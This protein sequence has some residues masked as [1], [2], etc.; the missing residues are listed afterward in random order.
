MVIES[1]QTSLL[2][3][4]FKQAFKHASAERGQT[5]TLWVHAHGR[6]GAVGYGEGCPREYVTGETL[7]G[8]QHFT[9]LHQHDWLENIH[10]IPSLTQWVEVH[11]SDIDA[12]PA[13]WT[14]VELSLLD[15]FGRE[16]NC[17]VEMLLGMKPLAGTFHYTAVLGDAPADQFEKQLAGYLKAGF[18][19]FKVKLSG[20]ANDHAKVAALKAAGVAAQRVRA[21]AN[22]L[23]PDADSAIAHLQALDFPFFALEEPVHAGDIAGMRRLSDALG[24]KIILDES[25]LRSGQLSAFTEQPQQWIVNLRVSKM[26]G[27]LRSLQLARAAREHGLEIIVGAHVGETSILTRAALTVAHGSGKALLAQEGAFGTHLLA[28]DMCTPPLM[29]GGG[30]ALDI[31]KLGIASRPGWGLSMSLDTQHSNSANQR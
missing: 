17:S 30:G 20:Q 4:P 11:Q 25:L 23:W 24:A 31:D 19:S 1:F 8:A 29:F 9:Q 21:D 22:N 2:S 6:S 5:Q 16:L 27:V 26:G 18:S 13:A 3:I 28:Y 15:L 14:A 12:N 10:S 7:Q